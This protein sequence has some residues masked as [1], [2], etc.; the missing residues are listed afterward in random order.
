MK[1]M[2]R[3]KPPKRY[4]EAEP[5]RRPKL[6]GG[7]YRTTITLDRETH[8]IAYQINSTGGNFSQFVRDLIWVTIHPEDKRVDD[9]SDILATLYK[10]GGLT[11]NG[12]MKHSKLFSHRSA[13]TNR[14]E[15][16]RK[17]GFITGSPDKKWSITDYGKRL[18]RENE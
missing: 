5:W 7:T 6:P 9:W 11:T 14:L 10:Y 8:K 18:I 16:L 15:Q 17:S 3:V 4:E 13:L 12:I 1:R 2:V